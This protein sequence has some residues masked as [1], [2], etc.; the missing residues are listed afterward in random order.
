MKLINKFLYMVTAVATLFATSCTEQIEPAPAPKLEGQQVYFALGQ[1]TKF[2]VLDAEAVE[3]PVY[4]LTSDEAYQPKIRFEE[5]EGLSIEV[6]SFEA[7]SQET[8]IVVSYD[9]TKFEVGETKKINVQI[10]ENTSEY[11]PSNLTLQFT[12]PEPWND[13]E[14]NG[15]YVDDFLAPFLEFPSGY[16]ADVKFQQS[17]TDANRYRVVNPYGPEVMFQLIGGTPGYFNYD[18]VDDYLE[19]D[20]TDPND[21]KLIYNGKPSVIVPAGF[22]VNFS[23]VGLLDIY[24]IMAAD[25]EGN[26]LSPITFADGVIRFPKEGLDFGYIYSEKVYSMTVNPTGKMAYGLPGAVVAD[27]DLQVKYSGLLVDE[28]GNSAS[29]LLDF[30]LGE[31]VERFRFAILEGDLTADYSAIVEG[32][33]DETLENVISAYPDE[34]SHEIPLDTVGMYTVVAVPYTAEGPVVNYAVAYRFY[35]TGPSSERPEVEIAVVATSAYELTGDPE[36]EELYPAASSMFIYMQ[37]DGT[38]LQSI[39]AYVGTGVPAEI[40]NE[41]V[42]ASPNAQDLSAYIADM[43]DYGYALAL[44]QG[45]KEGTTYD[46]VLGFETIYGE[47]K[48]F[49]TTYTPNALELE[50]EEEEEETPEVSRLTLPAQ[51]KSFIYSGN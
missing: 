30:S 42:L 50:E 40:S 10:S 31:D 36:M 8:K 41:E 51:L 13:L 39:T 20:V 18:D 3:V 14:G 35:F 21:V 49:R 48:T 27:Y 33:A 4:R 38:K 15:T 6:A 25:E 46:I 12:Y 17:A 26:Y 19:F 44:Y 9:L 5:V 16:K 29:A 34:T 43:L 22:Q 2:S 24:L 7:G 32:I 28:R 23:D 45:L 11:G 47:L 1:Q 37:A